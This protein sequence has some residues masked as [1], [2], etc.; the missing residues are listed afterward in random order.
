MTRHTRRARSAVSKA[1]LALAAVKSGKALAELA[2]QYEVHASQITAW[3]APLRAGAEGGFGG[4]ASN[5]APAGESTV[6]HAKIALENEVLSGAL[7]KAS[8]LRTK[9]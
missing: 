4:T 7:K 6:L 1:N 3:N 8:L 5:A 2:Q 9:R